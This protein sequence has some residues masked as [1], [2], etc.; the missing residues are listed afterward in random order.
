MIE[1][2]LI[3][4]ATGTGGSGGPGSAVAQQPAGTEDRADVPGPDGLG[5]SD[6]TDRTTPDPTGQVGADRARR[7]PPPAMVVRVVGHLVIWSV[8]FVPTV[9]ELSKGWR[10]LFDDANISL[11]AFRVFSSQTPLLGQY[12]QASAGGHATFSPGPLQY[13]LLAVPVH[14]DPAQG[15]LWGTAI[16]CALVLS[17]AAEAAWSRSGWIG[18]AVVAAVVIDLSWTQPDVFVH[19]VWN[20]NVGLVFFVATVVLACVVAMG[21][22][23]WWPV[24]VLAASVAAQS[25]LIFA[26]SAVFL[27][28]LAPVVGVIRGGRPNRARWLWVGVGVGVVCWI[29]PLIQQITTNPG[30]VTLLVRNGG[31]HPGLGVG[32]GLRILA[33]ASSPHPIWLTRSQSG[34]FPTLALVHGRSATEG[35]IVLCA[36]VVVSAGAWIV[37]QKDLAAVGAM[38]T[39]CSLAMVVTF[40]TFPVSEILLLTYLHPLWWI[41]GIL[42]WCVVIWSVVVLVQ[43]LLR[44]FWHRRVTGSEGRDHVISGGQ[45]TGSERPGGSPG[46]GGWARPWLGGVLA[47]LVALSLLVSGSLGARALVVPTSQL[48]IDRNGIAQ[49]DSIS[50]V[51]ESLVPRGPVILEFPGDAGHFLY[52]GITFGVAYRLSAD[53]WGPALP[54]ELG[55]VTGSVVPPDA[56]WPI[57]VVTLRGDWGKDTVVRTR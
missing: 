6:P 35:V 32:W 25:H 39:V 12:S 56:R 5:A 54:P 27:A 49:V 42:L 37:G 29:A 44:R 55:A 15:A 8:I 17:V 46:P 40:A 31:A 57:V 7:V 1:P 9:T 13:W 14:I 41:P 33:A 48:G 11:R 28:A 22:V 38:A 51:V 43:A 16:C 2:S 19:L 26:I 3:G 30:N 52:V 45:G 24:L 21:S 10:P 53:G 34:F 20:P 47:G 36:I 18:C 50:S 23:G 4:V